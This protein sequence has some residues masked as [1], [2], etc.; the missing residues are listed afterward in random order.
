MRDPLSW[1]F[2]LGRVFGITVRVHWLFP[3]VAFGLILRAAYKSPI[4]GTWIDASMLM[5]LLFLSV[6]LHEFGHCFAARG[7]DGDASDILLWPL[8]GLATVDVPHTSRANLLTTLGGPGV[9]LLLCLLCTL[10]LL[11]LC[12]PG[13]RPHWNLF[14]PWSPFRNSEGA[15]LLTRLDGIQESVTHPWVMLLARLFFVNWFLF[16]LNVL[17]IG[18]P[19]DGGRIFQCILWP[20]VGYR[21]AMLAAIFAGY[22]TM[23]IVGIWAIVVEELLGLCLAVFIY[24]S[25]NQQWILLENGG[26]ESM[27]GYDFSQGYTS[28]EDAAPPS[29]RRRPNAWQRWLRKRTQ[30]RMQREQELREAE[31]RRTDALLEKVQR[32]GREALTAEELRF[33][34]RVSDRYRNRQ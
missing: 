19:L 16:L 12:E 2:P 24:V 14:S 10:A 13:Y 32:E 20:Y 23:F 11:F 17:L 30:R 3:F 15:L 6:L 28:L 7:V 33:L 4:A 9:N 5:G 22:I 26:E 18:F 31:E 29:R 27:F 34:K 25:C 21:Q 1:S 8:G